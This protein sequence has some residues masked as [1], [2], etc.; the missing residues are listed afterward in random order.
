MH[1]KQDCGAHL[2]RGWSVFEAQGL[3]VRSTEMFPWVLG[4]S[5]CVR[6]LSMLR[7]GVLGSCC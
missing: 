2:S 1:E 5:V 6:E 4:Q 3:D 7:L